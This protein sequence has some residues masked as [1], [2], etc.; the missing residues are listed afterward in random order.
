MKTNSK[1]VHWFIRRIVPTFKLPQ[2]S[3]IDFFVQNKELICRS[4]LGTAL[5]ERKPH[6]KKVHTTMPDID[7]DDIFMGQSVSQTLARVEERME[8]ERGA[9]AA[10]R[11]QKLLACRG[12]DSSLAGVGVN[13]SDDRNPVFRWVKA[14]E[15]EA[16]GG[17]GGSYEGGDDG[18]EEEQY[19]SRM[20]QFCADLAQVELEDKYTSMTLS[21]LSSVTEQ[22]LDDKP[23]LFDS[24]H[25]KISDYGKGYYC[26]DGEIAILD[27][28]MKYE[29]GKAL[30]QKEFVM[31]LWTSD[32]YMKSK[33]K[34]LVQVNWDFVDFNALRANIPG[35]FSF[36]ESVLITIVF[37]AVLVLAALLWSVCTLCCG[38]AC[39]WFVGCKGA[40]ML[41][42]L[43][44]AGIAIL[45]G[46]LSQDVSQ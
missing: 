24:I 25:L 41:Q 22:M 30:T 14:S 20:E 40:V 26:V 3:A 17:E 44:L 36:G 1:D 35:V 33:H 46:A 7:D 5:F 32:A 12:R 39:F 34:R 10:Q 18:K 11:Q 21:T 42:L 23:N 19:A 29:L 9:W 16:V 45:I 8:A 13:A 37:V 6:S 28:E 27:P 31:D 4:R 15:G 38:C 43:L 2:H